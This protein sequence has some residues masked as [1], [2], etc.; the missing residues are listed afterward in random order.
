MA[1]L[2]IEP[3]HADTAVVTYTVQAGTSIHTGV[4]EAVIGVQQ[5]VSSFKAFLALTSVAS[6]GVDTGCSIPAGHGGGALVYVH[7]AP[8]ALVPKGAGAGVLLVV[9][10]G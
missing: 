7:L 8:G 5:A 3:C 10:I 2:T 9:S 1:V 6:I 4:G